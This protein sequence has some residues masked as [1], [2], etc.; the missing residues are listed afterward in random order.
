[1]FED[2]ANDCRVIDQRD[3]VRRGTA[4]GTYQRIDF[5]DLVDQSRPRRPGARSMYCASFLRPSASPAR[6]RTPLWTEKPLWRQAS[7][8]A[9]AKGSAA[10]FAAQ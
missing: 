2:S 6:I 3:Y 7:M 9:G 10:G 8:I 1:M 5:I 4:L